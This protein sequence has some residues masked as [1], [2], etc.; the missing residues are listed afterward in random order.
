M[1]PVPNRYDDGDVTTTYKVLVDDLNAT[2]GDK[3]EVIMVVSVHTPSKS[4]AYLKLLS[5]LPDAPEASCTVESKLETLFT[6]N[7]SF[8][9]PVYNPMACPY[10]PNMG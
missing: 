4:A 1:V 9:G 3:Y 6:T 2:G 10:R 8:T 5:V 7:T